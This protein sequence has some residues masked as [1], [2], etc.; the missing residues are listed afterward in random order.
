MELG[1]KLLQ[2]NQTTHQPCELMKARRKCACAQARHT[3]GHASLLT[4]SSVF[5]S[6]QHYPQAV[7]LALQLLRFEL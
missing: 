7:A 3:N 1:A 2:N 6:S 4:M 5:R